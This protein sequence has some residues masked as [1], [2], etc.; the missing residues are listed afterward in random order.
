[1]STD[2]VIRTRYPWNLDRLLSV[3]PTVGQ[4][5]DLCEENY[6]LFIYL[7]PEIRSLNGYHLSSVEGMTDLHLEVQEQ[8]PYTTLVRLTYLF[9]R[10]PDP[11]PDPDAR[12]RIYHDSRQTEIVELRQRVLPLNTGPHLPTLKQKWRVNLFLSKWLSYSVRKGHRFNHR[13]LL[14]EGCSAY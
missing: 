3:R 10:S 12:L 13:T 2:P 1:M 14:P 11:C 9:P 5:M 8:T 6:H 4:L 7:A